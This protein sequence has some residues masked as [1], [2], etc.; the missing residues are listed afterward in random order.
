MM[1][2]M[3]NR[4]KKGIGAVLLL[5]LLFVNVPAAAGEEAVF[6]VRN[7]FTVLFEGIPF[8]AYDI[9]GKK[10]PP[11]YRGGTTYL[12][13]RALAKLAGGTVA[14]DGGAREIRIKNTM[15]IP[16]VFAE[17]TKEALFSENEITGSIERNVKVFYN[18][19]EFVPRDVNGT[20]I[21]PMIA[22]GTTYL[23][24]RAVCEMAG[25]QVQWNGEK[26][27]ISLYIPENMG[28]TN[29]YCQY[30]IERP[31][32]GVFIPAVYSETEGAGKL[33]RQILSDY[34]EDLHKAENPAVEEER[35][36]TFEIYRHKGYFSIVVQKT[37]A[38]SSQNYQHFYKIYHY[39]EENG[40]EILP[41][42]FLQRQ[43]LSKTE[44][45]DSVSKV[46]DKTFEGKVKIEDTWAG[47]ETMIPQIYAD[48]T[49]SI[50]M[51]THCTDGTA[52]WED[53]IPVTGGQ[54][55]GTENEGAG[56]R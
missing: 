27:E 13:V 7:D 11:L 54:T 29:V 51:I 42:E 10:V 31:G 2:F 39:D 12:P 1:H 48:D 47:S 20:A 22:D 55:D 21:P 9:N 38:D 49:G 23:P 4:M 14:W 34:S 43:N 16:C 25:M 46:L 45:L 53:L 3:V 24:V 26:K 6:E 5:T 30:A 56:R 52:V 15:K 8:T 19:E 44:L 18:N 28:R 50:W 17:G 41:E 36:L 35:Y 32:A 37:L 40:R 33:N